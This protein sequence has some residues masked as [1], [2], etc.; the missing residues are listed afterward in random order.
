MNS[1]H[2]HTQHT[3][4]QMPG[5][6]LLFCHTTLYLFALLQNLCITS[7]ILIPHRTY[8][9]THSLTHSLY[10]IVYFHKHFWLCLRK[11]FSVSLSAF[12]SFLFSFLFLYCCFV[13]VFSSSSLQ[14]YFVL[15]NAHIEINHLIRTKDLVISCMRIFATAVAAVVV[16]GLFDLTERMW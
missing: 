15:L 9:R 5:F 7:G 14:F 10:I 13:F 4:W 1:V 3:P 16:A 2:I 6:C 8:I 12:F 11:S